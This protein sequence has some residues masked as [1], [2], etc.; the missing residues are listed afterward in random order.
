MHVKMAEKDNFGVCCSHGINFQTFSNKTWCTRKMKINFSFMY[1]YILFIKF[2]FLLLIFL[3]V[4]KSL[5]VHM[6]QKNERWSDS[7]A[8]SSVNYPHNYL[9]DQIVFVSLLNVLYTVQPQCCVYKFS[10]KTNE[11]RGLFLRGST[12]SSSVLYPASP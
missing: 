10:H 12:I 11:V 3:N 4:L 5:D 2:S 9:Q 6:K 7:I 8:L 1:S